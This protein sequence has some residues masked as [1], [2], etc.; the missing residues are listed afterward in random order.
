MSYFDKS[1]FE[2]YYKSFKNGTY[3]GVVPDE[4]GMEK[5]KDLVAQMPD[6][7][8]KVDQLLEEI[9]PKKVFQLKLEMLF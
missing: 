6:Q 1:K 4:D 2:Y 7:S 8:Q 5:I 3:F 9:L